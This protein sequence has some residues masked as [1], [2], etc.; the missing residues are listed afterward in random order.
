MATKYEIK[1]T[2]IESVRET[3][4]GQWTVVNKVPWTRESIDGEMLYG[5][6]EKFLEKSP[7]KE[8]FGYADPTERVT[9]EKTEILAQT[10]DTLDIPAVIKAINGL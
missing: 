10:V 7:L 3:R 6:L 9:E 2:K 5:S 8:V 4:Q 1:I